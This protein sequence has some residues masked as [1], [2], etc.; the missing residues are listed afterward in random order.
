M[1]YDFFS[2]TPLKREYRHYTGLY[3]YKM[4][5]RNLFLW[6][7]AY[8]CYSHHVFHWLKK[9]P[10]DDAQDWAAVSILRK[11]MKTHE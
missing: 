1:I 3:S 2:P 8:A 7:P 5:Y 6:H 11:N 4:D 10:T 9:V